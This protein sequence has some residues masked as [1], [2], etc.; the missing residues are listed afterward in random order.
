MPVVGQE[1][2]FQVRLGTKE[3][4]VPGAP[5]SRLHGRRDGSG[6]VELVGLE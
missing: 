5:T 1:E 2:A 4:D 3:T 6:T